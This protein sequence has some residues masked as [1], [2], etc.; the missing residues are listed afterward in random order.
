VPFSIAAVVTVLR[1]RLRD[2]SPR[3]E[4]VAGFRPAAVLVPLVPRGG[5]AHLVFTLRSADLSTHSGQVSFPGGKVDEGDADHVAAALRE[6][7][8][9]VGLA[10][11]HVEVIGFLDDV[12]T[13]TGFV[14][15]PVV[16]LVAETGVVHPASGEVAETFDLSLAA[17]AAPGVFRD[18]GDVERAGRTYRLVAFE[19][20]GRNIW[21]ATARVV[22]QLLEMV[23]PEGR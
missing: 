20:A 2:R 4:D 11:E 3:R 1:A 15:R 18:M 17:L 19:I 12:V 6:A 21:G 14:I 10:R 8:E 7:E 16:G 9:E 23:S 5:A 22:A 13:P